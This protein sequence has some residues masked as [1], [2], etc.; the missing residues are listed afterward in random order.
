[1]TEQRKLLVL[2]VM[3]NEVKSVA[4]GMGVVEAT[5]RDGLSVLVLLPYCAPRFQLKCSGR[6]LA[7]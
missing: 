5:R 1:M 3:P 4:Y 6:F 7:R 2:F